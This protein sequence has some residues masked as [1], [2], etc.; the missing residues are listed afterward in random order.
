M[1]ELKAILA[2]E[3]PPG[4]YQLTEDINRD[5]LSQ[6]CQAKDV[7]LFY[8]DGKNI[9]N[10]QQLLIACTKVMD[11]PGY[12]GDNW[13]ALE[14]CLTDLDWCLASQYLIVYTNTDVLAKNEPETW[15]ML[16]AI[17]QSVVD[18]WADTDTPMYIFLG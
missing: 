15:Q 4:I 14:D 3:K 2:G 11:F 8:L 13:D 10:K 16:T 5:N 12:F 18:Y 17:L 6:L 1:S 7:K 9:S